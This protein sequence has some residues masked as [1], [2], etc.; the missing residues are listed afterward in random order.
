MIKGL[1]TA[2]IGQ[3]KNVEEL[4]LL[5]AENGFGAIDTSGQELRDFIN[6]KGIEEAK[7]F[8]QKHQVKIG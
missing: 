2:G 1:S 8:L 6:E 3:V 7:A 5:A 4:V